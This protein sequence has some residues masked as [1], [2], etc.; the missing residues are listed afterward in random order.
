MKPIINPKRIGKSEK[1]GEC[2][3]EEI[4]GAKLCAKGFCRDKNTKAC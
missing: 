3:K 2:L 1:T 4:A